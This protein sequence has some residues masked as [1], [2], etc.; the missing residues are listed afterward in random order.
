M[1]FISSRAHVH[2]P[3]LT[4]LERLHKKL[5]VQSLMRKLRPKE[6]GHPGILNWEDHAL[7]LGNPF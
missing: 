5:S 7:A 1:L 4:E 3:R 6:P 2:G